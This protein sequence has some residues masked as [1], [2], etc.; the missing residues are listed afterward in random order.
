MENGLKR[1]RWCIIL[2]PVNG[3]GK[4]VRERDGRRVS[5]REGVGESKNEKKLKEDS[6][7]K[8]ERER[9]TVVNKS[10][11]VC[12]RQNV[13]VLLEQ[14]VRTYT[15]CFNCCCC[16]WWWCVGNEGF[17]CGLRKV[18]LPPLVACKMSL[19][20]NGMMQPNMSNIILF[21]KST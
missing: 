18:V 15:K 9:I 8:R 19:Q 16:C 6:K 2:T 3:V 14:R 10:Q 20:D 5:E 13:V 21:E 4:C 12:G 7:R 11:Q 1:T 17:G